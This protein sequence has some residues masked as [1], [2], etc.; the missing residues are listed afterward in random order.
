MSEILNLTE[1][2]LKLDVV[3]SRHLILE[4]YPEDF[5]LAITVKENAKLIIEIINVR[6]D[7]ALSKVK[8]FINVEKNADLKAVVVDF[9]HSDVDF[10]IDSD[11]SDN[12]RA[13]YDIASS[14]IKSDKKKFA[15]HVVHHGV[16]GY[17]FA[18]MF[19]VLSD[20][21]ELGFFGITDIIKGA[22]K[23][24]A[25]QEGKIANLSPFGKAEVSPVL[26]I[27]ENDVMASHGAALGKVSDEVL[28]YLMSRGLTKQGATS[29][30]TVGYLKPIVSE[31]SDEKL[32][33]DL[34]DYVEKR[35]FT[36][37]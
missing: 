2:I 26:N 33:N 19:G 32:K 28:F 20:K 1:P 16:N 23:T 30:M 5:A 12:A 17:S 10:S 36:N 34:L 24:W 7:L 29:L 18:K 11:L 6:S 14:A 8:G 15:V 22:K 25:R 27:D 35:K 31:I 21:A 4:S 9:S 13:T 3:C 37:D